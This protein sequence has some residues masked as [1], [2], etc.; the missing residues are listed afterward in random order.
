MSA[1]FGE[2]WE[3]FQHKVHLF[4][5]AG[6]CWEIGKTVIDGWHGL[7]PFLVDLGW[8]LGWVV[9]TSVLAPAIFTGW[10]IFSPFIVMS[11]LMFLDLAMNGA[12]GRYSGALLFLMLV[13]VFVP[14]VAIRYEFIFNPIKRYMKWSADLLLNRVPHFFTLA[15]IAGVI[16]SFTVHWH[17]S[18]DDQDPGLIIPLLGW[19]YLILAGIMLLFPENRRAGLWPKKPKDR[20]PPP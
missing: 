12:G 2:V 4:S 1:K 18:G 17:W 16:V 14:F 11:A 15:A 6:T 10:P 20:V 9:I 8:V 3:S 7:G 13:S 19:F 5:A